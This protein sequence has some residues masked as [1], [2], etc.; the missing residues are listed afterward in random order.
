MAHDIDE[1][2][3]GAAEQ[4]EEIDGLLSSTPP[5]GKAPSKVPRL[6]K[7]C[8]ENQRSALDY[9]A[10]D[11]T[12]RF[13]NLTSK[14]EGDIY[15]SA[16]SDAELSAQMVKRMPGVELARPE[17]FGAIARHQPYNRPWLKKLNQLVRHDKHRRFSPQEQQLEY[18]DHTEVLDPAWEGAE[19]ILRRWIFTKT[20]LPVLDTLREIQDGLK[21]AIVH[22]S[23]VANPYRRC[24]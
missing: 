24:G 14:D 12:E 6:V 22:V 15:P 7:N 1:L 9:L 4:I 21:Q 2:V 8:V 11:I 23:H 13:G 18:M 17:I 19:I 5:S 20:R 3:V 16:Q 10:F